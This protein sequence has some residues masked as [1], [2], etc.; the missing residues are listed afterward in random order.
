MKRVILLLFVTGALLTSC[1]DNGKEV[2]TTAAK[3]VKE[4]EKGEVYREFI[5]MN[6]SSSLEW[7]GS[8]LG[9]LQP[10][11]G[12]ISITKGK[13]STNG[14]KI[15]AASFKIDLSLLTVTSFEEGKERD[16]LTGH[17]K[18]ADLFNI[19]KYPNAIFTI[20]NMETIEGKYN[21]KIT[22]NLTMLDV[23]KSISFMAHVNIADKKM[24]VES[25]DFAV[26]RHDWGLSYHR[27]GDEGV[28]V[29]YLIAD[30]I[31]FT[32][33]ISMKN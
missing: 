26:N 2:E 3:E 13:V 20:T 8:H 27:E 28:P 23:T 15:T 19:E 22:G 5:H 25:E 11:F 1:S 17:L 14:D 30:D 31:G 21:S 12:E 10:R 9:G 4:V 33:R 7:R 29:D 32:I 16:D 6:P 24:S 18:S